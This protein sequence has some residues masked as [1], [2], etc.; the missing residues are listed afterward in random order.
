[1]KIGCVVSKKFGSAL[2][3]GPGSHLVTLM[4]AA[5]L[6]R[7]LETFQRAPPTWTEFA[8]IVAPSVSAARKRICDSLDSGVVVAFV[9]VR[10]TPR[11]SMMG[12]SARPQSAQSASS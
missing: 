2:S 12:R 7:N 9:V 5:I 8:T 3:G 6:I 1:M 4:D 11:A 10:A